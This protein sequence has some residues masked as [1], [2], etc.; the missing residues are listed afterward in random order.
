MPGNFDG[1]GLYQCADVDALVAQIVASS[2]TPL[3]DIT[4]DGF[5]NADDLTLWLAEA[6]DAN[7]A[8]HNPYL[9]GDANLDG[10]V[11]G[12][13]FIIWNAHKFTSTAKWCSGDF[14][15]DGNVDGSDFITWNSNKF[16]S[17]DGSTIVPEPLASGYLKLIMSLLERVNSSKKV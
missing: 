14:N 13:D 16:T 2:N 8:S 4:G 6:G 10:D 17:A 1:N 12:S 11:D 7:L 15:A 9:R 3:F 5:V